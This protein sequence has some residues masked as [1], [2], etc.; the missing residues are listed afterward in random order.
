MDQLKL[1]KYA[2]NGKANGV[3]K[4]TTEAENDVV[5]KRAL[6]C[7]TGQFVRAELENK[8]ETLIKPIQSAGYQVDVAL[9]LSTGNIWNKAPHS[10]YLASF[11]KEEQVL[12]YL[13]LKADIDLISENIT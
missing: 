9:V 12:E 7:I 5:E 13:K 2:L 11:E 3:E 8:M 10:D 1:I 4:D 6:V